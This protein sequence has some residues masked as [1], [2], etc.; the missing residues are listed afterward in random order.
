LPTQLQQDKLHRIRNQQ[1]QWEQT[2]QQL[3]E[4]TGQKHAGVLKQ[5]RT[6]EQALQHL[7]RIDTHEHGLQQPLGKTMR[8]DVK[9]DAGTWCDSPSRKSAVK[10]GFL[11]I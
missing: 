5:I 7:K 11:S 4:E 8:A 3:E 2:L 9:C 6:H 10:L 1:V